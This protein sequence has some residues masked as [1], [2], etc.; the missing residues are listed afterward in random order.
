MG[1]TEMIALLGLCLTCIKVGYELG[2]DV[3]KMPESQKKPPRS[4]K[5]WRFFHKN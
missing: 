3:G 4:S 2:K 5:T 1:E